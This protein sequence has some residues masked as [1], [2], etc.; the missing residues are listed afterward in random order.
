MLIPWGEQMSRASG[1]IALSYGAQC[2]PFP[3]SG[4]QGPH[5]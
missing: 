5:R 2:V 1:S 4:S 3:A